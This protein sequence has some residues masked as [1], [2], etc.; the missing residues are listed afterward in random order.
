MSIHVQPETFDADA[1]CGLSM[2]SSESSFGIGLNP[3]HTGR[4]PFAAAS[5]GSLSE[6]G[7]LDHVIAE[8]RAER[9]DFEQLVSELSMNFIDVPS[10]DVDAAI[11]AAQR[12]IVEALDF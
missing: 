3:N 11:R 1:S 9:P 10:A 6:R 4:R 7:R 5:I 2:D 12:R 8:P